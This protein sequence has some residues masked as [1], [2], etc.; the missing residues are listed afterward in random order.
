MTVLVLVGL[1]G[2]GKT[3][4]GK[5]LAQYFGAVHLDTDTAL[6]LKTGVSVSAIFEFEGES[7]FRDR[8]THL[9]RELLEESA[10]DSD[11]LLVMSTGG[12]IVKRAENRD[13]LSLADHVVYLHAS[14]LVLVDRLKHDKKRPLIRQASDIQA[15]IRALYDE[16]DPLYRDVATYVLECGHGKIQKTLNALKKLLS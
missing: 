12:G 2:V 3:T 10:F 8:E 6:T 16:R 11:G 14:P 4:V 13:L 5:S 9:L 7:G 15:T 1:P